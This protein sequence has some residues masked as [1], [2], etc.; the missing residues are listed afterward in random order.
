MNNLQTAATLREGVSVSGLGFK[1]LSAMDESFLQ[2]GRHGRAAVGYFDVQLI[3]TGCECYRNRMAGLIVICMAYGICGCF[4]DTQ[5]HLT[6]VD[7]IQT[8][9][10]AYPVDSH[11]DERHIAKTTIYDEAK[12]AHEALR[13]TKKVQTQLL[14][15]R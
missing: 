11:C 9:V 5:L 8:E 3:G 1:Y 6:C 14:P 4:G 12:I 7:L 2:L 15:N 13:W 10:D